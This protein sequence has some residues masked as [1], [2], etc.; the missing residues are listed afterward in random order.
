MQPLLASDGAGSAMRR[1][2][3]AAHLIDARETDL[4]HGYKE[5]S[6]PVDAAGNYAMA[7]D[8]LHIWPRDDYMLIALPNEDGSFTATLF[9]AKHGAVSF[10]SLTEDDAIERFFTDNFPDARALMPDCIGEFKAHPVGFL[11]TVA[12]APWAHRGMTLLIGDAA[13]AIV[14]FHG[15]GMNCCFEDCVELDACLARHAAWEDA[16]AEFTGL[17]KPNTDAIAAM[18][19]DNYLEMRARVAEPKFQLQQALSLELE[20]RFPERFVPRYSMVMFHHEIPY[21]TALE[22]GAIQA[23]L[24]AELTAGAASTLADI[25]YALAE[26][27]IRRRLAPLPGPVPQPA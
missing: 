10:A 24:L 8:A 3:S 9:L 2:M 16:F 17:R 22:R 14:P 25:D 13:H 15:Q 6:I 5:L 7:Q 11:G 19:L 18:A 21:R 4:E 23:R 26:R 12:A 20:R 1:C 27:E